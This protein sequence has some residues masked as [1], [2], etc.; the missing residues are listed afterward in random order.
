VGESVDRTGRLVIAQECSNDGS[1]GATVVARLMADHFESLDAPPL[2]VGGDDT[3]IPYAGPLEELW[4]PS[5]ERIADGVR[6]TL[7]Y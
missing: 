2:L 1:W 7:A 3:P 6:R 5:V 4:I